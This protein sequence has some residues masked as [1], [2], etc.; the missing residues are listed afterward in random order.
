MK[1]YTKLIVTLFLLLCNSLHVQAFAN[2]DSLSQDKFTNFSL[3]TFGGATYVGDDFLNF[4]NF[5][6]QFGFGFNVLFNNNLTIGTGISFETL[7]NYDEILLSFNSTILNR[8]TYH[9]HEFV[10]F[11]VVINYHFF[12]KSNWQPFIALKITGSILTFNKSTS[13]DEI[14]YAENTYYKNGDIST[15]ISTHTGITYRSNGRI[16]LE[17]GIDYHHAITPIKFEYPG[18]SGN[19]F[20]KK[21]YF[22]YYGFVF[23]INYL[24]KA[25]R[26]EK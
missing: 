23:G 4:K 18:Q 16:Q 3:S 9:Q 15:F 14:F 19:T 10:S 1:F 20:V 22:R 6:T 17:L 21:S 24:L 26:Y 7:K 25:D 12:P 8:K 2:E 11:P 5:S 13:E